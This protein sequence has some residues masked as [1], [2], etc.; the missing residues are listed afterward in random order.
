MNTQLVEIQPR[1]IK[2][3]F[4]VKK[5]CSCAVHL[6]NVTD[7]YVAFKV[8]TTSPKKYCVRPNVGIIKPKTTYDFTVTMQAQK[9]APPDM[10]CKDKFLIQNTV[11]PFGTTEE[12]ITPSMFVR[13]GEKYIEETKLRVLLISPPNS[14][15]MQQAHGFSKQEASHE[16][17]SPKEH[18]SPGL[19]ANGLIK[20]EP[21]YEAQAPIPE[22]KMQSRV[23]HHTP[24]DMLITKMEAIESVKNTDDSR[25]LKA[26]D[27]MMSF[28]T[29]LAEFFQNKDDES[30]GVKD[31]EESKL[32]LAKEIEDLKSKIS[33]MNSKLAEAEYTILKLN[34]EK[35]STI[36]E[37]EKL[38]QDLVM[39][40]R[41]GGSRKVRIGFPPLFVCM[42]ALI[43][44]MIGFSFQA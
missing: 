6:A 23:V 42:V 24:P 18:H 43:G 41:N 1:E 39:L 14:P 10:L 11:V 38:K 27:N 44:L 26:M 7:Q 4:E 5:Q 31:V 12:E 29:K 34:E 21:S 16:T 3:I 20:Q 37:K 35:T 28:P 30:E 25:S 40:R 36:R 9:S 2:F 15:V 22:E 19:P 13:D 8:K 17:P 33:A 32:K